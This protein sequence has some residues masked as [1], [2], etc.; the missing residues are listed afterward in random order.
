V[1]GSECNGPPIQELAQLA[2]QP[3]EQGDTL[4]ADVPYILSTNNLPKLFSTIQTAGRP[5]KVTHTYLKSLGFSSSN[6]R[7]L[8][9]LLRTLGFIDATGTPTDRWVQYK[10]TQKARTVMADAIRE[11]WSPLFA[12]YPDANRKDDEAVRNWMRTANPS[13]AESTIGRALST[14]RA[15]C[16]LGEFDAATTPAPSVDAQPTSTTAAIASA[17]LPT[18]S[19]G[20]LVINL[21]IELHIPPTENGEIYEKFFAAMKRHLFPND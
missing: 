6:D 13:I 18:A 1:A 20:G 15:V 16:K 3:G 14:F 11:G 9:G 12:L 21:N 19:H 7:Y 2:L 4:V 8:I 10:N 17:T 5:Q